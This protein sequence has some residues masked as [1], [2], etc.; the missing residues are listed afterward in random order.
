MVDARLKKEVSVDYQLSGK[1]AI[2]TAAANGIGQAI[3]EMLSSEGVKVFGVDVSSRIHEVGAAWA[4]TVV[5]DLSTIAGVTETIREAQ[6]SLQGVP[7]ILVNNVGVADQ[8]AFSELTDDQWQRSHD[9]NLMSTV[10][11][12]R[13]LLPRMSGLSYAAVVTISS[14]LAKQPEPMP[15]E[16]GVAKAGLLYLTKALSKEY[17]PNVRVNAV[18]PG[19]IWTRLWSGPGGIADQLAEAWNLSREDAIEHYLK[20]RY[21][22]LGFGTPEDVAHAVAYL[23]SPISKAITGATIDVGG[24]LRGLV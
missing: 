20:G 13:E 12:A 4:G 15:M 7:N 6:T 24:T 22:P 19:P 5:A 17:A 18:C 3:A 23:A 16:Y 2:V 10:R 1:T 11:M 21:M 9:L 8:S 14:D